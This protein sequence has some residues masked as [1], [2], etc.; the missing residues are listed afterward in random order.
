MN[1]RIHARRT[2]SA[3]AANR[4]LLLAAL[5]AAGGFVRV[6]TLRDYAP[7]T[8]EMQFLNIA[9]ADTL[10]EVFRR[11][12]FE[13]HPPLLHILRHYLLLLMPDLFAERLISV[14]AGLLAVFGVYRIGLLLRG[15]AVGLLSALFMSFFAIEISD[16]MM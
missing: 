15:A 5:L 8:H 9:R 13:T 1:H 10:A 7:N 12:L 16:S 14:A 2:A 3:V 11:G 4:S 6:W